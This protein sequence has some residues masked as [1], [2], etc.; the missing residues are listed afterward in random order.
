MSRRMLAL[1][2]LCLFLLTACDS[3]GNANVQA[4]AT[5][6]TAQPG[7]NLPLPPAQN[8][9][10]LLQTEQ[11]LLM[12][13]PQASN[14]SSLEQRLQGR[15]PGQLPHLKPHTGEEDTFW[16]YDQDTQMYNKVRARLVFITA[17]IYMYVEDNQP[18]NREA[19]QISAE[20]FE[21][22][23]YPSSNVVFGSKW[24]ASTH[25]TILN[26]VALGNNVGGYFSPLD[27]YPAS[28]VSYSNQRELLYMNLNGEIPGSADYDSTLVNELQHLVDWSEDPLLPAWMDEGMAILQQHTNNY[29]TEGVD[30]A[31]LRAA[32]TQLNDWS[33]DPRQ[34]AAYEGADYLFMDYFASHYGGNSIL[35]ELLADSAEPPTNFD[36]VLSKNGYTDRFADV[37][38]KWLVA[39]FVADPSI[40][41]GE[42]GTAGLPTSGVVPQHIVDSYPFT[43]DDAVHQYAAEYYDLRPRSAKNGLLTIQFSGVP[44]VRIVGNNP[45]GDADEWWGNRDSDLDS[46][47][48]RSFDLSHLRGKQVTLQFATWF[49]LEPNHDYAFVEVSTDGGV[50]WVT[51]KGKYTTNSNSDG[52]N[53]G[54]GYTGAS[55][56]GTTPTWVQEQMDLTP[57]AG[58]K[59]QLRFEEV[60]DD[61]PGLQGFALDQIRI[62]ELNFQD[63]LT[64]DNGWVSHSFVRTNNLLP[65][66]YLV[67]AI[68]YTGST[69]K[70]QDL[71][72]DLASGRGSVTITHFGGQ[73]TRVV[74]VVAAYALKTT[75]QAQYQLEIHI[76]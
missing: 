46:T 56:G 25:L 62:P 44:T 18:F 17:H 54:N 57:Y 11:L 58:R 75:L 61:T 3:A 32:D 37:L 33:A 21:H 4:T 28:A 50:H 59:V 71:N 55:G 16:V 73:V 23:I 48:T 36:D 42:Y 26:T 24:S 39:N 5:P 43:E 2:C 15:N 51:L 8:P 66:H 20:T 6:G 38:G 10:Q 29:S 34:E 65:E 19:L 1:F 64:S 68:V 7:S 47:L 70:I 31:F 27:T 13:P 41:R 30:Q 9:A 53:W 35:K 52:L 72:V 74:L 76:T 49:D 40:D 63:N 22:Q 45:L 69:F 67:Q 60:T 14:L 12:T